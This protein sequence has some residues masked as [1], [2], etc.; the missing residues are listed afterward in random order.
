MREVIIM[1]CNLSSSAMKSEGI[2]EVTL[3]YFNGEGPG[4]G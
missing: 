3:P 2:R 4:M 1:C